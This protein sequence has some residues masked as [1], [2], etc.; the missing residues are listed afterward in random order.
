MTYADFKYI[1]KIL[2]NGKLQAGDETPSHAVII[3]WL[4]S[5][6]ATAR[7]QSAVKWLATGSWAVFLCLILF[8]WKWFAIGMSTYVNHFSLDFMDLTH[9]SS[10]ENIEVWKG[11]NQLVNSE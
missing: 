1:Q 3:S 5:D 6:P 9:L 4:E 10:V 7:N 11:F 8:R 2:L